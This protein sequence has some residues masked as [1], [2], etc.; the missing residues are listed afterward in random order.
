MFWLLLLFALLAGAAVPVQTGVNARLAR[1]LNHP[2]QAA[3]V[4]F[5]VGT[6]V[7]LAY[8]LLLGRPWPAAA[9]LR[10]SAPWWA[11]TGGLLGAFFIASL[12]FLAPRLGA[13]ALLGATI[14]GQM[15]L[16]V[17]LDHFGLLGFPTRPLNAWRALGVLLV[18]AGV[19]LIR[20]F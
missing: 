18:L 15:L 12:I 6:A 13:A 20:R 14:A 3:L 1:G 19:A 8:T 2:A 11:W 17:L 5:C 4:S 7:L 10:A 16:A 9:A